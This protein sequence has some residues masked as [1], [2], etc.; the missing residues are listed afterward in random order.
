MELN[1]LQWLENSAEKFADK[2]AYCDDDGAITFS[3]VRDNAKRI[4]SALA[5]KIKKGGAVAVMSGRHIHTPVIFLGAVYAGCFYAPMDAAQPTARL[6]SIAQTLRPD[7][8]IADDECIDTARQLDFD[9]EI[10]NVA[11][12]LKS[13]IDESALAKIRREATATDPLYVIFTS[14]STGK[15]KGVITSMQS[16][17]L[18]ITAYC[19]VMG[20]DS[21]DVLGNQSPLDYIAAIRDIYLPLLTGASTYI[22][23][24]QYF[25]MPAKLFDALCD[26]KITSVGWSVSVFTIAVKMGAFEHTAPQYLTKICFSGSVMPCSVLREWQLNLPNA[27][28]VNQY[29]PTEATASCTYYEVDHTV[30]DDEVLPIGVPYKNYNVFLLKDDNTPANVGEIGEIC[31]SGPILALGYYNNREMTEKSFIQN[32]LNSAF[33]ERIYKTGDLGQLREDGLLE[34]KGR[35]DRQI[36][37]LGHRVELSEIEA[38]AAKIGDISECCALYYKEK[39]LIYLFYSGEATAKEIAVHMRA[40]LPG[41]MVPRKMIRLDEMPHLHNGK[42]DMQALTLQMK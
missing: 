32:P 33:D 39:E 11:E 5:S 24:K 4:G 3:Q 10:V 36:K 28:F 18:Y 42:I 38:Q 20:I 30:S 23:P 2:T 12:L 7:I 19:E 14:G 1:V 25:S 37:H 29:G 13:D 40:V 22:I 26:R 9:G 15:P 31:V 35:R 27:K 17:M 21:S 8:I 34:F 41:F 16:L 6:N